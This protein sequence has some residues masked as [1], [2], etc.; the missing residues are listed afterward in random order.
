MEDKLLAQRGF[1]W[2]FSAFALAITAATM[3]LGDEFTWAILA[4]E[5]VCI[6]GM[7]WCFLRAARV[8]E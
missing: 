3:S 7:F 8:R 6:L 5:V 2:S 4:A 1:F